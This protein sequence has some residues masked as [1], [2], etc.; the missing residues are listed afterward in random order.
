MV[1]ANRSARCCPLG[2]GRT[3]LARGW[4]QRRGPGSGRAGHPPFTPLTT[5]PP[6]RPSLALMPTPPAHLQQRDGAPRDRRAGPWDTGSRVG[7]RASWEAVSWR[8]TGRKGPRWRWRRWRRWRWLLEKQGRGREAQADRSLISCLH[9]RCFLYLISPVLLPAHPPGPG[10]AGE[11][12][13]PPPIPVL[14]P[15][16]LPRPKGQGLQG[17]PPT[18][19]VG[20]L[21]PGTQGAFCYLSFLRRL[22]RPQ[23][24]PF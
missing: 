5:R 23:G 12:Q 20:R 7:R 19:Q 10:W 2:G 6:P 1:L 8:L 24:L 22:E 16:G 14:S 11:S 13:G 21:R 18:S 4:G 17:P 3:G 15:Q 9:G